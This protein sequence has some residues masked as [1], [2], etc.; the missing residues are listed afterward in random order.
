MPAGQQAVCRGRGARGGEGRKKGEEGKGAMRGPWKKRRLGQ[1]WGKCAGTGQAKKKTQPPFLPQRAGILYFLKKEATI[2][3][4]KKLCPAPGRAF[5]GAAKPFGPSGRRGRP[6]AIACVGARV[7][8]CGRCRSRNLSCC[9]RQLRVRVCA[10]APAPF[11]LC[12]NG[13]CAW[14]SRGK[15]GGV[16]VWVRARAWPVRGPIRGP[17]LRAC[18]PLSR[19][20]A[21]GGCRVRPPSPCGAAGCRS[22]TVCARLRPAGPVP[23]CRARTPSPCGA[24]DF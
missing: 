17:A 15:G 2:E 18:A 23:G 1:A 24:A 14:R 21:I 9:A 20:A 6:A 13:R 8:G 12:G 19:P 10:G 16:R 7:C 4:I 3:K 22:E 5:G 11:A